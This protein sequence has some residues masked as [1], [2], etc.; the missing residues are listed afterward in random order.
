MIRSQFVASILDG[1]ANYQKYESLGIKKKTL[2][3]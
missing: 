3:V 2:E 1:I